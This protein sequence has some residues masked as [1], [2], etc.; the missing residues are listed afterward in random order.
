M[1]IS[2]NRSKIGMLAFLVLIYAQTSCLEAEER[3]VNFGP[4]VAA[5]EV[6]KVLREPMGK[7]DHNQIGQNEK[8]EKTTYLFQPNI[9]NPQAYVLQ[10]ESKEVIAK[11]KMSDRYR[12]KSKI[13]MITWENEKPVE[14]VNDPDKGPFDDFAL[15]ADDDVS[16]DVVEGV[17]LSALSKNGSVNTLSENKRTFHDLQPPKDEMGDVPSKVKDK[18]NCGNIPGCKV[19]VRTVKV[20]MVDWDPE[21][22]IR[23]D[24]EFVVSG[25][26]PFFS[27][28]LKQCDTWNMKTKQGP[29]LVTMC[30][31]MTD[32][33][34]GKNPWP[35][36]QV[37]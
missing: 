11:L 31:D 14:Q 3:P 18:A 33:E 7:M 19:K 6:L 37:P 22:P 21:G 20:V 30:S 13:K 32:F 34:P 16:G 17:I 27:K 2:L 9:P 35:A 25:E 29:L 36:A 23:H 26:L 5:E 10:I 1:Q 15:F 4:E 24:L 12:Y 28:V 8:F